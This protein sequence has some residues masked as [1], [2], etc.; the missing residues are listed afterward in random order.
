MYSVLLVSGVTHEGCCHLPA[1]SHCRVMLTENFNFQFINRYAQS[2]ENVQHSLCTV[3]P[4]QR[5][6][7]HSVLS[8]PLTLI[9]KRKL[10]T[11]IQYLPI[12]TLQY[13]QYNKK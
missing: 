6:Y 9:L 1:V 4:F 7:P 12:H 10:Y 13:I 5:L 3:K 11:L 8:A 2:S